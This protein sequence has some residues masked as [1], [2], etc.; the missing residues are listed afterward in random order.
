M[1]PGPRAALGMQHVASKLAVYHSYHT[2]PGNRALHFLGVP[3]IVFA[4][5]VLASL[6]RVRVLGFGITPAMALVA[7]TLLYYLALDRALAL[8]SA[9][10][11]IALL[12]GAEVLVR[13]APPGVPAAVF[14]WTF[15]VGWALQFVGH[16]I[17]GR[18]PAFVDDLSQALVA[19][20]YLVAQVLFALGARADLR[21]EVQAA[22]SRREGPA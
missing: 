9:L 20:M 11:L 12:V 14:L 8:F 17:E 13:S 6:V 21:A 4:L 7:G 19:P 3:A 1:R 2:R 16:G 18:R 15:G 22:S 5:L 10:P